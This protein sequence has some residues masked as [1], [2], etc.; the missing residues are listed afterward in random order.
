MA[1]HPAMSST[2][3][4]FHK[5]FD[6][7]PHNELMIKLWNIGI[8]SNLWLW[9]KEYLT[10]RNQRVCIN[11]C[12]SSSLPVISGVPQ[13]SILGPILFLVYVNDLPLQVSF[14][15]VFLFADDTKCLSHLPWIP[16][17]Y[18]KT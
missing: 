7:V 14:S 16:L 5:A 2:Y 3:L 6:S 10:D 9:I 4:D 13:E 1:K 18:K 11:G 8:T 15:D 12:H 17:N